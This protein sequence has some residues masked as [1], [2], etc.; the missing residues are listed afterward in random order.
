MDHYRDYRRKP[1][2]FANLKTTDQSRA[3][4]VVGALRCGEA[5]KFERTADVLAAARTTSPRKWRWRVRQAGN[6]GSKCERTRNPPK[7]P[8]CGVPGRARNPEASGTARLVVPRG[9]K[10]GDAESL[11]P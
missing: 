2:R 1:K 10:S 7:R 8:D 3:A 4:P 6:A 5:D 9:S 11:P